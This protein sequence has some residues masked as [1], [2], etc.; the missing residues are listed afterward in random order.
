MQQVN[1]F[2]LERYRE[3]LERLGNCRKGIRTHTFYEG[4]SCIVPSGYISSDL[5]ALLNKWCGTNPSASWGSCSTT[6]REI[7][8]L[9]I[10][11][12]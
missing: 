9:L 4:L 7:R 5:M 1:N 2:N 8:E 6:A 10:G 12:A 3:L 11:K